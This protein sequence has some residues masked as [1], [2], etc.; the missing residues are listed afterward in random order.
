MHSNVESDLSREGGTFHNPLVV[1][2]VSS[3]TSV[4]T[5]LS[6]YHTQGI[7]MII[8]I[9]DVI[10]TFDALMSDPIDVNATMCHEAIL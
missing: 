5:L 2:V 9:F 8:N 7:F 3:W 10:C 1:H 4:R 6:I